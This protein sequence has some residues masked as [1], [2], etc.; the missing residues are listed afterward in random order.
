MFG[1]LPAWGYYLRHVQG[2]TFDACTSSVAATDARQKL[3]TDDVGLL[4]GSP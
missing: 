1:D 4:T 3:V 2:V